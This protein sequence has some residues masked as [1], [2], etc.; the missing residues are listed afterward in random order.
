MNLNPLIF[1]AM[2]FG[3]KEGNR[4]SIDFDDIY[5]NAIKK[6][7]EKYPQDLDIIRADEELQLGFIH[8]PMYE[9]LLLSEIVIADLTMANANVFY[10]L[11]IRHCAKP[12]S[13][14]LIYSDDSKLPFDVFPLRAISYKLTDGKLTNKDADELVKKIQERMST[15]LTDY[16]VDSPIF[17]LITGFNGVSLREEEM[18][19]FRDR[20]F[21]IQDI[22]QKLDTIDG[23][24]EEDKLD[25]ISRIKTIEDSINS[26]GFEMYELVIKLL[27][28]YRDI[29]A[30]DEMIRVINSAPQNIKQNIKIKELLAF[31][32]NRRNNRNDRMK[33]ISIIEE[34]INK[35]GKSS[36]T[37]GI[38][39]RMYKDQYIEAKELNDKRRASIF[40]KKAIEIYYQ[41]FE[42]DPR[43]YYPG[44]NALNLALV[45]G[46]SSSLNLFEKL[47]PLIMF[48]LERHESTKNS[49][50]WFLA[51]VLEFNCLIQNWEKANETLDRLILVRTNTMQRNTTIK[52]LEI[53][54]N[55][56]KS[57]NI[58][59]C[60]LEGIIKELRT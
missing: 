43:D 11:G 40:L 8:G 35:Y 55:F 4:I 30:W 34:I 18:V 20:L 60:E 25:N 24:F 46:S 10:E 33:A 39:G 48:A 49:D 2:P 16:L 1:V 51:T 31:A 47:K 21:K 36:E 9:R 41:G 58:D 44:I 15:A 50:Y 22:Y 23:T 56:F 59:Y 29:E 57:K 7:V 12:Y 54:L 38:L 26:F 27:L 37:L 5:Y 13:T 6:A 3:I 19:T 42:E 28:K 53:T 45:E 17:Q 32:L 52:N 14:I